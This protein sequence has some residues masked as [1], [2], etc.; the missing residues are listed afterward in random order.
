[1]LSHLHPLSPLIQATILRRGG[2]YFSH[3]TDKE[4]GWEVKW[5][6]STPQGA[7]IWTQPTSSQ[8][9]ASSPPCCTASVEQQHGWL[10]SQLA[11]LE[12]KGLHTGLRAVELQRLCVGSWF[13]LWGF[14]SAEA[15]SLALRK[16]VCFLLIT[17]TTP[18]LHCS[19]RGR[20]GGI[21][22]YQTATWP[23]ALNLRTACSLASLMV[24]WGRE[25]TVRLLSKDFEPQFLTDSLS[26]AASS[27]SQMSP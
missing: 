3:S 11:T 24:C 12:T 15:V 17:Q 26:F 7:R 10:S 6:A 9:W 23:Y 22:K 4:T 27:F 21:H 20:P 19:V 14:G 5:L 16:G 1:M 13:S 25:L 2:D 8:S 18:R